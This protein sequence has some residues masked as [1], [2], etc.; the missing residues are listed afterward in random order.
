MTK[1]TEEQLALLEEKIEFT[2]DGF[3]IVGDLP[4]SVG[5]DVLGSVGRDV[6]FNVGRDVEGSV[7]G[8][9]LGNVR[10][11]VWGSVLGRIGY[12]WVREETEL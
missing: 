9:V 3:D 4:G 1:F 10:R 2:E 12:G 11:N 6:L 5:R 7:R 8:N